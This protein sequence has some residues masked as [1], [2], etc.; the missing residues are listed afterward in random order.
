MLGGNPIRVPGN[1]P[2]AETQWMRRTT[3]QLEQMGRLQGVNLAGGTIPTEV[4]DVPVFITGKIRAD[5]TGSGTGSFSLDPSGV[6]F[7][8]SEGYLAYAFDQTY[9]DAPWKGELVPEGITTVLPGNGSTEGSDFAY[10]LNA[11][12]WQE[13]DNVLLKRAGDHWFIIGGIN[14]AVGGSGGG[15]TYS[16]TCNGDGT[17]TVT[18][19]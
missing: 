9:D 1:L 19:V 8:D 13:G 2:P 17:I 11:D 7:T 5:G 14:D 4:V 10:P 6:G 12:L 3:A 16:I 18:R 15:T